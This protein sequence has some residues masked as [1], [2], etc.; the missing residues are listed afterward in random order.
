MAKTAAEI[1]SEAARLLVADGIMGKRVKVYGW[2]HQRAGAGLGHSKQTREIMVA[3]SQSEVARALGFTRPNQVFNLCETANAEEILR[4]REQPGKILYRKIDA[5]LGDP[6]TAIEPQ[7]TAVPERD[8]KPKHHE[9]TI[10]VVA[11]EWRARSNGLRIFATKGSLS[12]NG[13]FTASSRTGLAFGCLK[14]FEEGDYDLS[15]EAAVERFHAKLRSDI[16]AAEAE[17]AKMRK[18]LGSKINMDPKT[19][20]D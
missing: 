13:T 19:D 2:H 10:Y 8:P 5:R 4:A 9:A 3:R 14:R 7:N 1:Q 6:W 17:L 20:D 16:E 12:S 15:P 11:D 18:T